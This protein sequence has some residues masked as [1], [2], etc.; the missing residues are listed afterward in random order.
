[1]FIKLSQLGLVFVQ[2]TG[3]KLYWYEKLSRDKAVFSMLKK[4]W[5][6]EQTWSKDWANLPCLPIEDKRF[7]SKNFKFFLIKKMY[8]TMFIKL[9]QYI[10]CAQYFTSCLRKNHDFKYLNAFKILLFEQFCFGITIILVLLKMCLHFANKAYTKSKLPS[11]NI[12]FNLFMI[13][14]P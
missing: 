3:S 8:S 14:L 11:T 7:W 5:Q 10:I 4:K 9:T 1:M 12:S 2:M 13:F 6:T